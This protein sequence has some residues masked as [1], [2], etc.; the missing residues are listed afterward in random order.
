MREHRATGTCSIPAALRLKGS[1]RTS[2]PFRRTTPESRHAIS[3]QR[4]EEFGLPVAGN[5]GDAD[6]FAGANR[7]G[8]V[9][10]LT[11]AGSRTLTAIFLNPAVPGRP[12]AS[13][14]MWNSQKDKNMT[15]ASTPHILIYTAPNCPD[16][17]AL[18]VGFFGSTSRL[19]NVTFLIRRS[20]KRRKRAL[21]CG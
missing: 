4:F 11:S 12:A 14:N 21:G 6:D 9:L 8:H 17:R 10:D 7:Q 18:R 2:S 3:R 5:T 20:P 15:E 19:T 1:G 16:C 13:E